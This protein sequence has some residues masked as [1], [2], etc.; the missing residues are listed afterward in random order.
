M[1]LSLVTLENV[2]YIFLRQKINKHGNLFFNSVNRK[3]VLKHPRL[4]REFS[5]SQSYL[6]LFAT[7]TTHSHLIFFNEQNFLTTLPGTKIYTWLS[8]YLG[9]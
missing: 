2:R 1:S 4:K 8:T 6:F 5:Q 9:K 3:T 7:Y